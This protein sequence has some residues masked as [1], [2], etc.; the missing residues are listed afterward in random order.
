MGCLFTLQGIPCLYYGTEQ[1]LHGMGDSDQCVREA[2]WGKPNA[3]DINHPFYKAIQAISY[4]RAGQP[5]LRYG[6][7]YFR[8]ISG[9]GK[10][11]GISTTKPGILA[12]SRI[13]NDTEILVIANTNTSDDWS[14]YVIVDFALNPVGTT[15]QILYSNQGS[16]ET[17]TVSEKPVGNVIIYTIKGHVTYGPVRTLP[18]NLR[19]MEIQ[20]LK[21]V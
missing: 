19:P 21:A 12:F 9:N 7:Q 20:V 15:Y 10:E 18:I 5:A 1:G 3:F 2:L 4:L 17:Q 6:R 8:E 16:Q 11:F 13:L 14:G